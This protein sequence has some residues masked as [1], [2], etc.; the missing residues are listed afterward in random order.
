M[1][2]A[3]LRRDFAQP[4]TLARVARRANLSPSRFSH[5]FRADAGVGPN[6]Y[7]RNVRLD[8]AAELLRSSTLSI[9]EIMAAVGFND[10]SHFSR[11]FRRRYGV[12]P[13]SFRARSH[14]P[15]ALARRGRA[16]RSANR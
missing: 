16:A 11:D 15:A 6:Q 7:L 1:A 8:R 3:V 12:S 14:A 4:L 5:L 2:I 10:P 9:K 13:Q